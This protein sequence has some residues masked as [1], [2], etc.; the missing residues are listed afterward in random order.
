VSKPARY[1]LSGCS[2]GGKSSLLAEL[3][4]R[5][6]STVEEP[7][8]QI[9]QEEQ[10]KDGEALPWVNPNAFANR[11]IQLSLQAFEHTKPMAGPVFFDRSLVDAISYVS[12]V[13]GALATE[14]ADLLRKCRYDTTVFLAP[15]W[16]QIFVNDAERKLG[17]E[18]AVEEYERLCVCYPQFGYSPVILP[19]ASVVERADFVLSIIQNGG[20][21]QTS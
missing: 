18:V 13:N 2:G 17:F 19:K 11:A 1:V 6:F 5:G 12:H 16:E 21:E 10:A 3:A 4:R 20:G 9:V 15:P 14:H 7:G 8:R